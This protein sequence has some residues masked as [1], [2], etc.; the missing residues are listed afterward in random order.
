[1]LILIY[2]N[3]WWKF[4]QQNGVSCHSNMEA[5]TFFLSWKYYRPAIFTEKRKV[6]SWTVEKTRE[7]TR[8]MMINLSIWLSQWQVKIWGRKDKE[9]IHLFLLSCTFFPKIQT[10]I[11]AERSFFST[12]LASGV[13]L[14]SV[15]SQNG[16]MS[17]LTNESS[18]VDIKYI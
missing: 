12:F 2:K 1:M 5:Y 18:H 7:I 4:C 10:R 9:F 14:N 6:L 16:A 15:W 8:K 3:Q 13:F 17:T 11:I